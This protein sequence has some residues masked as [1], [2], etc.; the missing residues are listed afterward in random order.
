MVNGKDKLFHWVWTRF[1]KYTGHTYFP[2]LSS[3]TGGEKI[4]KSFP[5]V[6]CIKVNWK[7]APFFKKTKFGKY[8]NWFG[9][10]RYLWLGVAIS[11][12]SK[13][14]K[15]KNCFLLKLKT[16]MVTQAKGTNEAKS[17]FQ[18]F[19]IKINTRRRLTLLKAF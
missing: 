9:N 5:K 4:W 6:D 2:V 1:F 16:F 3:L 12:F 11:L 15:K 14:K 10:Q 18:S 19:L 13:K 17:N 7:S 8:F